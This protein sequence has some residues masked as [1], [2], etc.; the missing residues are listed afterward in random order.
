MARV[1]VLGGGLIGC[2]WAAAF[3]GAGHETWV[4]DPDP[5]TAERLAGV[6]GG[7]A[8]DGG[9]GVPA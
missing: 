2:G 7:A 5:A 9:A 6:W 8:G 1:M 4:V 3:A